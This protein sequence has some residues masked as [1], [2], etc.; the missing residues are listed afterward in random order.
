MGERALSG[1]QTTT[2]MELD[3]LMIKNGT[4]DAT[5][6]EPDNE[7]DNETVGD[8]HEEEAKREEKHREKYM[9][10]YTGLDAYSVEGTTKLEMLIGKAEGAQANAVPDL[11]GI[12]HGAAVITKADKVY[13]GCNIESGVESLRATAER[14]AIVKACSD[15]ETDFAGIV[16]TCDADNNDGSTLILSG[17]SRQF[18][19]EFGDFPVYIVQADGTRLKYTTYELFPAAAGRR[20]PMTPMRG[21]KGANRLDRSLKNSSTYQRKDR[22]THGAAPKDAHNVHEWSV[23]EVVAWVEDTQELP[24]LG[25]NFARNA[26]DGAL[27]LQLCNRDL[28]DMLGIG[29]PMHRRKL[30]NAIDTLRE[31]DLLEYGVDF[32]RVEDYMALLD[33]D[34]VKIVTRLKEAFD[35][36]DK[37]SDGAVTVDEIRTAM[38]FLG[39]DD[40]AGNV[41]SWISQRDHTGNAKISFE[42]FVLAYTSI[43][44]NEDDDLVTSRQKI[45]EK[46]KS[47]KS[48]GTNNTDGTLEGAGKKARKE[49]WDHNKDLPSPI[50]EKKLES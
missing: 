48:K 7:T 24:Q 33:A 8:D 32:G 29:L 42:E 3:F 20:V 5:S 23:K 38:R 15:G 50:S 40:S 10:T 46:R 45:R 28:Q 25:S 35:R 43:F 16:I 21:E 36:V 31:K 37:N 49:T 13:T 17:A 44:S 27:L 47:L 30:M 4:K 26:V 39:Q 12:R 41:A 2:A 22:L 34:R 14:T 6:P 11:D 19:A 9:S 18:L 1:L